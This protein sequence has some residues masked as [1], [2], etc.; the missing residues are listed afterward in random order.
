MTAFADPVFPVNYSTASE[1]I[2]AFEQEISRSGL[3]I[4]GATCD[5][6]GAM[7]KCKIE[8]RVANFP[9]IEFDAQIASIVPGIGIAVVFSEIPTRAVELAN[10][11]RQMMEHGNELGGNR[12]TVFER[13]KTMNASKKMQLALSGDRE[14]RMAL[15]RDVNKVLHA[16]VLKNPR[17]GLDE[18]H[19]AAKMSSLSPEALKNISE[20]K[21]WGSNT[22][23]CCALVRNPRTPLPLAIRLLN[24]IPLS[25]IRALAKGGA[26]DQIVQAAR[27]KINS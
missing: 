17:I 12:K 18:V 2:S 21:E 23:I 27:K 10:K 11:L 13:L 5:H 25:E 3:L 20:H 8:M 6:V 9:A 24:K 14:E 4:R 1:Y 19:Y 7:T 15:L 26:R 22:V 16:F